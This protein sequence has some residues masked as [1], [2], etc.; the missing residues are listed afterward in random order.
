MKATILLCCRFVLPYLNL[1]GGAVSITARD[2]QM[3]NGMS[4]E[5]FGLGGEDDDFYSRLEALDIKICRFAPETSQYH[6]MR[7]RVQ[8]R[9]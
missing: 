4:N 5:F 9:R 3:I 7:H 6:K 2:F 1:F 8:V